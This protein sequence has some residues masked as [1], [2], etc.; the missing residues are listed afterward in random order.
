MR[1]EEVGTSHRATKA[2]RNLKYGGW[3]RI[4]GE[5]TVR[6]TQGQSGHSCRD[7]SESI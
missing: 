7:E 4:D 3:K 6:K 2:S 1:V 5:L